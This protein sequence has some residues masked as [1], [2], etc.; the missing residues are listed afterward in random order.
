MSDSAQTFHE[1][2]H[3]IPD[4]LKQRRQWVCWLLE[5]RNGKWTK[6][7]YNPRTARKAR[8]N[9]PTTWGGFAEAVAALD[10]FGH[11]KGVGYV[12]SDDD[13]YV[14]IDLDDCIDETG[15]IAFWA[16]ELIDLIDS[17]TERSQS[18]KGTHT[19]ARGTLPPKGRRKGPIEMYCTGRFFA[20]TGDR[21]DTV[22]AD[23]EDRPGPILAMHA[24]VFPAKATDAPTNGKHS[25]GTA[26]LDDQTLIEKAKRD[27]KTGDDFERLWNGDI[28]GLPSH[29]EAE[30][31]L[32]RLLA[33]WTGKD[34]ARIDRIFRMSALYRDK[35]DREDYRDRTIQAAID[36]CTR[37]YDPNYYQQ[38]ASSNGATATEPGDHQRTE[39]EESG[40]PGI[41]VSD[42]PLRAVAA[43]AL[44]VLVDDNDPPEFFVRSGAITRV[45]T[46]ENLRPLIEPVSDAALR[47]K[48]TRAA[49]F[50]AVSKQG[51]RHVPPPLDV[52]HDVL[53]LGKWPFPPLEAVVEVPVLRPDGSILGE[54]GY[55]A[56]TRLY[57]MPEPGLQVPLIPDK[58]TREDAQEACR[59]VCTEV[60]GGFPYSGKADKANTIALLLTPIIRQ[61]VAGLVPIAVIDAPRAGT[62][63][64]LL[65]DVTALIPTG[66]S[67]GMMSAP[68]DEAEWRKQI[69]SRLL[70]G[71]TVVV[72]DNVDGRLASASLARA[73]TANYWQDRLLG[74]NQ[75]PPLPQRATWI[76]NGNNIQLGGDLPRRCYRIRLDAKVP[77]PWLRS[78]FRH[79]NLPDWV[80]NHR[81]E[82]LAA[83]LTM[84]RAWF[85][86]GCPKADTPV[87]GSFEVWST[88]VGG[89]LAHLGVAGFLGNL[90]EMYEHADD[91]IAQWEGFFKELRKTIKATEVTARLIASTVVSDKELR[92]LLPD[93]L[94][95]PYER[96]A[97]AFVKQL[98]IA[99]RRQVD[100]RYGDLRLIRLPNDAHTKVA[101]WRLIEGEEE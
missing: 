79:E 8:V 42:R 35:W 98:G 45:R 30:Y 25:H 14:A 33:F 70:E 12:F 93:E 66:R 2:L 54:P 78:G 29:S 83:L 84:C 28:S 22:P 94:L 38:T 43:E 46:D 81:G 52:I 5:K 72:I 65:S 17:Y 73:V 95:L 77:T 9:D 6:I 1:R 76:V 37:C 16:R 82:L 32:C 21:I 64:G 23:I 100:V 36:A 19:I 97:G 71:A 4:E 89:I 10:Q 18:L 7:P 41:W 92:D 56:A 101:Q 27:L 75:Q 50:F 26:S 58:P 90:T 59:F 74:T 24:R 34:A 49:D 99:L 68:E 47:G 69:T 87:L 13:P 85:V 44:R 53:A 88:M 61:A 48:L 40:L 15:E 51:S 86:A 80:R 55:D 3:N 57:F 60:L 62:G 63:K 31:H 96:S 39:E 67:A 11:F 20:V 91:G